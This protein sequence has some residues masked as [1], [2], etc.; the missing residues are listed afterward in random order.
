M[1]KTTHGQGR[2]FGDFPL[3]TQSMLYG[4]NARVPESCSE[5]CAML[6]IPKSDYVQVCA[7]RARRAT[8]TATPPRAAGAAARGRPRLPAAA[9]GVRR[10]MGRSSSPGP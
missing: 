8:T 2:A 6:L 3:V 9:G 5:G 4:F 7:P 10:A 1:R